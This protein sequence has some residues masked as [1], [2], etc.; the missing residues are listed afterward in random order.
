MIPQVDYPDIPQV[1]RPYPL[2]SVPDTFDLNSPGL[3]GGYANLM[4][5]SQ[6]NWSPQNLGQNLFLPNERQFGTGDAYSVAHLPF[7]LPET[8]FTEKIYPRGQV[9]APQLADESVVITFYR[10]AQGGM[11]T[12]SSF[13]FDLSATLNENNYVFDILVNGT[14]ILNKG[15]ARADTYVGRPC[16]NNNE[17]ALN[18][19][20]QD[21]KVL[22]GGTLIELVVRALAPVANNDLITGGINVTV[23]PDLRGGR[24]S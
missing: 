16:R 1:I 3:E 22:Q 15:D 4:P 14:G 18:F 17:V 12:L 6:W 24:S 10:V 7:A 5:V 13:C 11:G 20:D 9:L 21:E 23:W 19:L 2:K 8:N